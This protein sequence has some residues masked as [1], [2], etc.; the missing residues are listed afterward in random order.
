MRRFFFFLLLLLGLTAHA[1]PADVKT[2]DVLVVGGG[3]SGVCA[4]VQSARL[5]SRTL[6]VERT[7]GWAAC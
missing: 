3:T 5:G 7:P 2:Y 6:L 4:A 1:A